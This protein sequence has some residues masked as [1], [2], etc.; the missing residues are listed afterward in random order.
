[1]AACE[2][3]VVIGVDV[4][5][6]NTDAVLVQ[7]NTGLPKVVSSAKSSTTSDVTTGIKRAVARSILDALPSDNN[8]LNITQL[9]IG[10]THFVNALVQRKNLA[11]VAVI[12]LC[13]AASRSVPP[14]SDFDDELRGCIDGGVFMV[15]GGYEF[16][17]KV[18]SE[19]SKSEIGECVEV[20]VRNR[21]NNIVVCGVFSP[22]R[23]KQE[24]IVKQMIQ[25]VH[26][27]ISVTLSSE[28]GQI[29]LLERE[30]ASILNECLKPLS[31]ETIEGLKA[32]ISDLGLNCPFYL[33]QN[34]GTI[35]TE[36][37]ARSQPVRTFASGPTN[38][39]RGAAF[40]SGVKNGIVIDIGGTTTDVGILQNGFPREASSETTVG[41]IRTNFRMPDIR[42]IGLGGGSY[43]SV[44][45]ISVGPRSAGY[46]LNNEA[47]AFGTEV[48]MAGRRL[49]ATDVAVAAKHCHIGSPENVS[50]IEP[51]PIIDKIREMVEEAVD[52]MKISAADLPVI[53][54]GGGTI[55]LDNSHCLK[56][57]N[58]VIKPGHSDVANA[59]GA[60][61]SQ[62]SGSVDRVYNLSDFSDQQELS[63]AIE[64]QRS[65]LN[66]TASKEQIEEAEQEIRKSFHVIAREKALAEARS[67][68]VEFAVDAGAN[69]ESIELVGKSEIP[70]SYL[71]GNAT[72]MQI[73]V[74]GE[75]NTERSAD[76]I[77]YTFS[78][79]TSIVT[80]KEPLQNKQTSTTT[81]EMIGTENTSEI[82]SD[83]EIDPATGEW[84]LSLW[85]VECIGLGAGILGCGGGG[86]PYLGRLTAKMA[87][88]EGKVIRVITKEKL[89]SKYRSKQK[90]ANSIVVPVAFMGAPLIASEKLLSGEPAKS[91]SCLQQ[92]YKDG[93]RDGELPSEHN[94]TVE[95]DDGITYIRNY[96]PSEPSTSSSTTLGDK[97]IVALVSAE[98]GGL[99]CIEPLLVSAELGIPVL[100]ADGMG[101]AFPEL[102]MYCPVIYGKR[103]FPSTLADCKGRTD[104][105]LKVDTAKIL[106]NHFRKTV[107]DMGC[108]A[109]V[110]ICSIQ[111]ADDFDKLIHYSISHAWRL[112]RAVLLSRRE[113]TS[114]TDAIRMET[115]GFLNI[116]GKIIDVC[117]DT[118]GG[119]NKG[120][121]RIDG[122]DNFSD[123]E[124]LIEFQN[125]NLIVRIGARSSQKD[126]MAIVTC[127]PDLIT[128]VD[129]DTG[130]PIPT[131]NVQYG[132]RVSVLT[133]PSHP[134]LR[135][136]RALEFVGPC[137]FGYND[138]EFCPCGPFPE[139][140]PVGPR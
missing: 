134:M 47:L 9:N 115:N 56:G 4:G 59:V 46:N 94:H 130:E 20:C 122:I 17:G 112:G 38:S 68:A 73:K 127:V 66:A 50:H 80:D 33:T 90:S 76:N 84:I 114:P 101:R 131:E 135:T 35:V 128:V 29:G 58:E 11:R 77:I 13:G 19:V 140:V 88:K 43:V 16:D 104:V 97:E 81:G 79:P 65:E 63:N 27:T 40:L 15:N 70:L 120:F 89:L 24:E 133:L 139:M 106:E 52:Q 53:L 69:R 95:S 57:A 7:V 105:V 28:I 78:M 51:A 132:Q 118:A 87:I 86:S 117:R 102:Q 3:K 110:T 121:I 22:V 26:P 31:E 108:S 85:D 37:I 1:M 111:V 123:K 83:P 54:V 32:A 48:D 71:P 55:L 60:A 61:L 136:P 99:N 2:R 100:D 126:D 137:A 138:I 36:K 10:T 34:D 41:G 72:R 42:S 64:I 116:I 74:V 12:R 96:Q 8:P 124:G 107:V 119:F 98:I 6:T 39:M 67:I 18:I 44:D 30:N 92:L 82:V 125:E 25:D 113:N 23:S 93:Y 109:G 103:P 14:F 62:V 75:L 91:L 5:G 49:T 129:T 45:P 21:I